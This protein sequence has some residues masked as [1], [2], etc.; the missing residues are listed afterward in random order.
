[1]F[2]TESLG[3]GVDIMNIR[4]V[5]HVGEPYRIINFD[6]EVGWGEKSGEIVQ[7]LTLLS[8]EEEFR[9]CRQRAPTLAQNKQVM[10][11]FL[12]TK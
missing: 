6:Q 10:H 11:K 8:D 2:V 1:M 5:I 12:T 9:L 3:A 4:T 7:S